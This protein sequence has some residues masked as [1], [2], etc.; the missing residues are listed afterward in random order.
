MAYRI[1]VVD[2]DPDIAPLL[3]LWLADQGYRV[4]TV[5]SSADALV[6]IA[7]TAP[8]LVITDFNM[9][10]L[11]G[12]QLL[13]RMHD[14]DN[15]LPVIMISGVAGIPDAV[16]AT[17]KGVV[18]FLPKPLEAEKFLLAVKHA[19]EQS[20]KRHFEDGF[21][22][23]RDIVYRSSEMDNLLRQ[24]SRVARTS[25]TVMIQGPSG[26]GKELIA[27]AIHRASSRVNKAF[28]S[29]NCAALPEQLLESE[30]FGHAKGSFTGAM[31]AH[32]GLFRAADGGTLF[33]DEI[34]DMPHT[35]QVRLLR[36]LQEGMVRPV[37]D[38]KEI[39]IDVRVLAATH[40][41]LDALVKS[42]D[43]REDLLYRLEVIPLRV[44]PL[45]ERRE[46]IAQLVEYYLGR[47]AAKHDEKRRRFS[48]EAMAYLS[49]ADWP[50]NVR[51]LSNVVEQCVVLS[52]TDIIPLAMAETALKGR[53]ANLPELSV[54]VAD[55]ES[56]YLIKLLQ[57]TN[58][59]VTRAARIAGRNRTDF[60]AILKRHNLDAGSFRD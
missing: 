15:T 38:V 36:V 26:S 41:D 60:Y 55:F 29:I 8:D 1:L 10:G 40:R 23:A 30:L 35:L 58:G 28:V 2:D 31:N 54:A 57:M 43:F 37:G 27:R 47:L 19:L 49:Q 39:P 24:V 6:R 13:E 34:G 7:V 21:D 46:D 3:E 52:V 12:I 22:F 48:P 16:R 50:G 32:S 42:G 59:N 11:D 33:L 17:Q 44:P 45:C 18:N 14:K 20:G 4:E 25:S 53:H 51:Q 5:S 9:P 56:G